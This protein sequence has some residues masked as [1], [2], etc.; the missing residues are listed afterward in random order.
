[1]IVLHYIFPDILHIQKFPQNIVMD[2]NNVMKGIL[3]FQAILHDCHY[4]IYFGGR[5]IKELRIRYPLAYMVSKLF[6][7][8]SRGYMCN[9][10]DICNDVCAK[11]KSI[12]FGHNTNSTSNFY[13]VTP[14]N[15]M[16]GCSKSCTM[17]IGFKWSSQHPT[18]IF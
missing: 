9:I 15:K 8:R 7:Q 5:C 10:M 4:S 2:L 3:S 14:H 11:I 1:M 13:Y 12:N 16:I 18:V 6:A 17:R